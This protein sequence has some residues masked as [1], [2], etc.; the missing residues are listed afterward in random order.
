MI[1]VP[2]LK[3]YDPMTFGRVGLVIGGESAE[4]QVSLNGGAAVGAA[5]RRGGD[6][7]DH[8]EELLR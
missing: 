6:H 5:L 4:R 7:L 3:T 2:P 1:A 8:F